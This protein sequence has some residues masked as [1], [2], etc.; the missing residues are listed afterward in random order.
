M[1]IANFPILSKFFYLPLPSRNSASPRQALA[2]FFAVLLPSLV[3]LIAA[4]NGQAQDLK[5]LTAQ[6]IE[7]LL[8]GNTA[9]GKWDGTD[10]RQFFAEDGNTIYAQKGS[11]SSSGRWRVNRSKNVYE[12]WWQRSDWSGYP[13][14]TDGNLYYWISQS[15]PPQS[16]EILPGE[17]LVDKNE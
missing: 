2:A 8:T 13:V 12:S 14:A 1:N 15:L 16:F 11:R 5:N 3:L 6:E 17:Q 10:Y 7:T 4:S 9:V